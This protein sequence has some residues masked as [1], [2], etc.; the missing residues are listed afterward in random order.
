MIAI[1]AKRF[2]PNEGPRAVNPRCVIITFII[3][4]KLRLTEEETLHEFFPKPGDLPA[5][6]AV[7]PTPYTELRKWCGEELFDEF[8]RKPITLSEDI[9][10]A[11]GERISKRKIKIDATIA[12]QYIPFLSGQ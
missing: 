4:H 3:K 5:Q 9:V 8:S 2:S 1:C 10:P 11:S 12:D 6:A 7:S